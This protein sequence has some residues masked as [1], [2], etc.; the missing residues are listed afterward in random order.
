[1]W[2]PW[3][4]DPQRVLLLS[5]E[6]GL[7]IGSGIAKIYRNQLQHDPTDLNRAREVASSFDPI[8]VGVLY[9]NPDVPCYEDL[10]NAGEQ[11]PPQFSKAGLEAEFDKFT[12]WPQQTPKRVP[13]GAPAV[14]P[15]LIS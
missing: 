14:E 13:P 5:H 11:R 12:V 4:H 9:R 3:L 6:R 2:E 8:P 7:K 15:G 1:M 10:R